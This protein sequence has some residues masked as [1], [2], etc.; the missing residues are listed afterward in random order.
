MIDKADIEHRDR[1]LRAYFE[2]RDWD[3]NNEHALK[4]KLVMNSPELLPDYA[5]IIDDEWEAEQN[6]GEQGKG[7]LIFTNG[8]GC[9]AVVEVK[10]IDLERTGKQVRTRRNEKRQNVTA[11]AERYRNVLA[12]KLGSNF[13]VEGYYFTSDDETQV[14][15]I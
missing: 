11:Q 4:R 5:F 6:R 2:G 8:E 3:G 13:H 1:V 15:K 12:T 7:D 14:F 10:W 9:F